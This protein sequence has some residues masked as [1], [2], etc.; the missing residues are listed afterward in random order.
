MST[1]VQGWREG[2]LQCNVYFSVMVLTQVCVCVCV[3]V[4]VGVWVGVHITC[5]YV[6][7]V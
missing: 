6:Q 4:G 2:H 5:M 1:S 3:C 7:K